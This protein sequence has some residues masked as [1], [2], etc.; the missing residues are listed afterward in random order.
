M[1]NAAIFFDTETTGLPDWSQP[2]EAPHQPHIVQL[3]AQLVNLDTRR[4]ISSM[5][6]IIRPDGWTIPQETTVVH[7]ITNEM[8]MD[9]GVPEAAAVE[10]FLGLWKNRLRIAHNEQFDA[11]IMRIALMRF[12]GEERADEFKA[13]TRA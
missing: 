2:S 10:M 1:D 9:L 6:V 11:R 13:G 3:A 4:V 7:G 8:A 12:F 5:D